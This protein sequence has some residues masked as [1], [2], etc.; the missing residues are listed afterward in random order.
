MSPWN[1]QDNLQSGVNKLARR[2]RR[3]NVRNLTVH[4]PTFFGDASM[5]LIAVDD[6][7]PVRYVEPHT[8]LHETTN[9]N[10]VQVEVLF[11]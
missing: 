8:A 11:D 5:D 2:N 3:R 9:V 1:F 4:I 10:I 6:I 7:L